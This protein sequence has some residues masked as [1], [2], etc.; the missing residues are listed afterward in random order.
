MK[1]LLRNKGETV[2]ETDGIEGID[3]KTGAP[4]TGENWCGGAYTLVDNY[5]E[6]EI[7]PMNEPMNE[8]NETTETNEMEE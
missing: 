6:P 3:W 8:T 2:K 7:E 5:V 1:A 4:L